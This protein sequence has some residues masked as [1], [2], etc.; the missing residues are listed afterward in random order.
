MVWT[1]YYDGECNLCHGSQLR[2]VQ[3]AKAAGQPIETEILQAPEAV[4]KGYGGNMV[5]EA[6]QVFH[7]HRAWLK[8]MEVAPWYLRWVSAVGRFPL[9]EPF[10]ALGY[11]LVARYRKKWFGK[12]ACPLPQRPPKSGGGHSPS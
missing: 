3:W 9:L 7:G 8:L 6:G 5:L 10:F 12:R 2:V 1:L 4:E 11:G